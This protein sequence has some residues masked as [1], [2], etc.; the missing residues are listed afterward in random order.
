MWRDQ[1]IVER[2]LDLSLAAYIECS[3]EPSEAWLP[4][5][6]TFQDENLGEFNF[7]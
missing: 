7:I 1:K 3:L 2:A 6:Q 5:R 4:K